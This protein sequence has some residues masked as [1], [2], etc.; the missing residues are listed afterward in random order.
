[1][2]HTEPPHGQGKKQ[3]IISVNPKAGTA[4]SREKADRLAELLREDGFEV[5]ILDN[6]E[7]VAKTANQWHGQGRLW[8]LIGVGGDGTAAELV[9]RTQAGV[10]IAMLAAGT[11]NLLS[12]YIGWSRSVEEFR[13]T[14]V[15]GSLKVFDAARAG[16]RVFLLMIGCGLDAEVV[17][18]VDDSRT[19][20]IS[21]WAYVKPILATIR[22]YEYPELL[23]YSSP[24]DSS[25]KGTLPIAKARWLFAF[26]L[27]CYAGGLKFAPAA[28]GDDGL[29]DVCTFRRGSL[30]HG[31]RYLLAVI[32]GRHGQMDD[33]AVR[34]MRRLKITSSRNV[35]YQLDG[36]PGGFLPV[37]V[38]VLP[39]RMT[40]MVPA[41]KWNDKATDEEQV[42]QVIDK[43]V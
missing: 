24:E 27:P 22:R 20:H 19:G 40:L 31:L 6:L 12:K 17:R 23:L 35:P 3:V 8:V 15:D 26:N 28:S 37:E 34:R 21:H 5:S 14:I 38:E 39:G 7:R 29:L 10:P 25:P 30:W 9:N 41:D 11:E 32:F 16:D 4:S 36:D 42:K 33:C 13:E 43:D 18:G 2:P 1:M